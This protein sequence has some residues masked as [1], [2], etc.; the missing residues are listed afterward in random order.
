MGNNYCNKAA[1]MTFDHIHLYVYFCL[2]EVVLGRVKVV[3]DPIFHPLLKIWG[4]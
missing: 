4:Y 3:L 2:L 1:V